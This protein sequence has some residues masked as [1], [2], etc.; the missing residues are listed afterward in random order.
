MHRR[1]RSGILDAA[2]MALVGACALSVYVLTLAPSV[3]TIFD[4]SLEFQVVC[5]TLGIAHPTGYPLY[6]MLGR[7]FTLLPWGDPAFRVNLM[8]AV[9]GA[10]TVAFVY[11][12]CRQLWCHRVAAAIGALAFAVSPVFWSQATIAEVYTLHAAFV[13]GILWLAL[14]VGAYRGVVALGGDAGRAGAREK[15]R[16]AKRNAGTLLDREVVEP[17]EKGARRAAVLA[18]VLGLGLTH[19]RMTLLLVPSLLAYLWW[20]LGSDLHPRWWGKL[21]ILTSVPLLVY[22]YIPVR[23]T[24]VSSLDGSYVNS[25][26]GFLRHITAADYNVFLGENPL[27]AEKPSLGQYV[28]LF[29]DQFTVVGLVLVLMGLIFLWGRRGQR[30]LLL[31]A[32]V[33]NLAFAAVYQVADFQVFF[34][35]SFVLMSVLLGLGLDFVLKVLLGVSERAGRGWAVGAYGVAVLVALALALPVP[36]RWLGADRSSDWAVH[37]L[38]LSWLAALDQRAALVGIRGETTLLRYFQ[39]TGAGK[40]VDLVAADDEAVRLTTVQRLVERGQ[41][42]YVTR[43][44]PGLGSAFSLDAKGKLIQVS[45]PE[46]GAPSEDRGQELAPGLRVLEWHPAAED[47]HGRAWVSVKVCWMTPA[48]LSRRLKFSVRV[49]RDDRVIAARDSEPVHNAYPTTYWRPGEVVEDWYYVAMPVG[50]CGGEVQLVLVAYDPETGAEEARAFLGS[51]T[52][53]RSRGQTPASEWGVEPRWAWLSGGYRLLGC[54]LG[55]KVE[56]SA[57]ERVGISLLWANSGTA[58]S[59]ELPLALVILRAGHV[60]Q[61]RPFTLVY[62]SWQPGE[63]WR[64]TVPLT[65]PGR[66]ESG[67]YRLVLTSMQFGTNVFRRLGWPPVAKRLTLAELQVTGREPSYEEPAPS[68]TAEGVL[69]LAGEKVA[70]LCGYELQRDGAELQVTLYWQALA[71]PEQRYKVFVHC[72]DGT[73]SIVAQSDA[74]PDGGHVPTN[75]WFAGEYV[76]DRHVLTLPAGTR[77]ELRLLAGMYDRDGQRLQV[78]SGEAIGP[79]MLLLTTLKLP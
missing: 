56:V 73:G 60:V 55:S 58:R 33:L 61:E 79:D 15:T 68:E 3:A 28:A 69:G 44:M 47:R 20:V 78:L 75:V 14:W 17:V 42:V 21:A 4:D 26:E 22:L 52:V 25:L 43:P 34:I 11:G 66:L 27:A 6:T 50:D 18:L 51:V 46:G 5:Y 59:G 29:R 13:A 35:P 62:E 12:L 77:G 49:L 32:L 2:M 45:A 9:F 36:G 71:E 16:S 76:A 72:L 30:L 24:V 19:H 31:P 1:L 10:L 8:S 7:A 23:A 74:E 70:R 54:S 53:P 41:K 39:A 64:Q 65:L 57:G 48:G 40:D 37:D 63:P 38:G 67:S